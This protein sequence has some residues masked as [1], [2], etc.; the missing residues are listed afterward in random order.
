MTG[1]TDQGRK[2]FGKF[3]RQ[4]REEAGI[5]SQT[6]LA[7][8]LTLKTGIQVKPNQISRLEAAIW[9]D[10]INV[11]ALI[12]IVESKL[13]RQNEKPLTYQDVIDLMTGRGLTVEE[14][15]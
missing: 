12:A 2:N 14:R 13:L 7:E 9:Q 8:W 11:N 10:A 1:V 6:A 3:L 4:S 15:E 5:T